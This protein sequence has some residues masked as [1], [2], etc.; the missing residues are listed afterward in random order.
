MVVA[1]MIEG[2]QLVEAN[3]L[4]A[5]CYPE[6]CQ[7]MRQAGHD[8]PSLPVTEHQA[9]ISKYTFE[10]VGRMGGG[11]FARLRDQVN[12]WF[13][14]KEGPLILHLPRGTELKVRHAGG[15]AVLP[16]VKVVYVDAV[17]QALPR[18][19]E[20]VVRMLDVAS[21]LAV[22]F[23]G[24]SRVAFAI[25]E[26]GQKLAEILRKQQTKSERVRR[27]AGALPERASQ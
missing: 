23:P 21:R 26:A 6:L 8:A 12:Q 7:K 19:L 5:K 17:E 27:A 14:N 3:E 15:P 25:R 10:L 13:K 1:R 2:G 18:E 9:G 16:E 11:W 22:G 24:G 4:A 20:E